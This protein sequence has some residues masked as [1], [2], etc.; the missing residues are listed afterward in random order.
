[1]VEI[2]YLKRRSGSAVPDP[3]PRKDRLPLLDSMIEVEITGVILVFICTLVELR[4][5]CGGLI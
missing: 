1:M 3:D 2:G 5:T 4:L